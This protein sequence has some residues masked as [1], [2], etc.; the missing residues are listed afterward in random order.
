MSQNTRAGR[1]N[2]LG[3][4]CSSILGIC[5]PKKEKKEKTTPV[6]PPRSNSEQRPHLTLQPARSNFS[7]VFPS[8]LQDSTTPH[9]TPE[10][11]SHSFFRTDVGSS[12]NQQPPAALTG[13]V[14]TMDTSND[15]ST[16]VTQPDTMKQVTEVSSSPLPSETL[17]SNSNDKVHN[18]FM[19][20]ES[21]L[22]SSTVK[23]SDVPESLK[24]A[25]TAEESVSEVL[26]PAP[27]AN[28][29]GEEMISKG[30]NPSKLN[31]EL[32]ASNSMKIEGTSTDLPEQQSTR[33]VPLTP[34]SG[35][36]VVSVSA[37]QPRSSFSS[38]E[39]VVPIP[40]ETR[41]D[42][43]QKANNESITKDQSKH[44]RSSSSSTIN[45][46]NNNK[47][48]E[49]S[50][51]IAAGT[52]ND[53]K[54]KPLR[55][56]DGV[57]QE[58]PDENFSLPYELEEDGSW[59][60]PLPF[61]SPHCHLTPQYQDKDLTEGQRNMYKEV[62]IYCN[63]LK[64]IPVSSKSDK[65]EG[66]SEVEKYFLTKECILRFLRATKWNASATK[67]RI[68]DTLV[69]RR[70]FGV[71]NMHPDEVQE[72]N[73][74]GK[75][76][77]LGYDKDGRPCLYLYPG[78]QNTKTSPLQ[79]R[80]LVY[81]LECAI[82]LMPP[83]VET[84]ALLIN[85]RDSSS[86][87]NPSVGQGKEVLNIL[88]T[89]YCERLGKA[90]VINI[91][92]AVWGFFKLIS[93]FIDPITREKLKFNEPLDRYVPMDQLDTNF[94]G[95]LKFEYFHEKYWPQIVEL[96]KIRRQI[97]LERWRKM[98]SKIGTSEW[99]IKGGN[100]YIKDMRSYVRPGFSIRSA[101]PTVAPTV[102]EEKQEKLFTNYKESDSSNLESRNINGEKADFGAYLNNERQQVQQ[103]LQGADQ[104]FNH[105]RKLSTASDA[106]SFVTADGMD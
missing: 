77:L 61:P 24:P 78:R 4:I 52:E 32:S 27:N 49:Q 71:N 8:Q 106:G 38:H 99:D 72:E 55:N 46:V 64:D 7:E 2:G 18:S 101:S 66:L 11:K 53:S 48:T 68:L 5:T 85:F 80:H 95:S 79:I 88:Q 94:G 87:S 89:H 37:K 90:L 30:R 70:Q 54:A 96:C 29:L 104:D 57:I 83:G 41:T 40:I 84:L 39:T 47:D 23:V 35:K 36:S 82:D 42:N 13:H 43:N 51:Q 65:T 67:K 33:S 17:Q 34:E 76:V 63:D 103:K 69:W 73:A 22:V 20:T 14:A 19:P 86:R 102:N 97:G 100:D 75:Q 21:R 74:T 26:S 58:K 81:F 10:F 15:A 3:R 6:R 31:K 1:R 91:P 98:G 62:F 59:N 28:D 60:A 12:A 50:N 44:E 25:S 56:V 45:G 16:S 92:W 93:P 105:T 9:G